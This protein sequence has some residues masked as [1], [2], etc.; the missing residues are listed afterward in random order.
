MTGMKPEDV[1]KL[2]QMSLVNR[3]NYTPEDTLPEDS[4]ITILRCIKAWVVGYLI[5][6]YRK[7]SSLNFNI[8]SITNWNETLQVAV[9]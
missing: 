7:V 4:C 8:F 3:E 2:N 6:I 5:C 1:I 9:F